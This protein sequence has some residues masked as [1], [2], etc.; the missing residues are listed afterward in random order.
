MTAGPTVL[1]VSGGSFKTLEF[2]NG[3]GQYGIEFT[4]NIAKV[5]DWTLT[6]NLE[7]PSWSRA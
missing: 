2:P 5:V 1:N 3:V 6:L 7:T 4:P